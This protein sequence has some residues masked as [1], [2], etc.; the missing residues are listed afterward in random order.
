M[1]LFLP[2]R[3]LCFAFNPKSEHD[4]ASAPEVRL[5]LRLEPYLQI[6]F[7]QGATDGLGIVALQQALEDLFGRLVDLLTR[8]SVER[9]PNKYFALWR[10]EPLYD[11]A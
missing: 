7:V 6:R 2:Q 9:P 1:P 10:T 11:C 4:T 8:E 5:V 3:A